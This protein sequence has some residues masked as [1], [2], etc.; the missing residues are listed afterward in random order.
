MTRIR[1][2]TLV[3]AML[4]LSL[5]AVVMTPR[6]ANVGEAAASR[7][8]RPAA[9]D[10]ALSRTAAVARGEATVMGVRSKVAAASIAP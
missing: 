4:G 10:V 5:A 9:A 8:D 2:R 3:R 7:I 1:S 6:T